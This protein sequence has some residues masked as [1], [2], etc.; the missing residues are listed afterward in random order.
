MLKPEL[1][2]WIVGYCS[3]LHFCRLE[4]RSLIRLRRE[5]LTVCIH[6][7]SPKAKRE[8]AT[9]EEGNRGDTGKGVLPQRIEF[10]VPTGAPLLHV[11]ILFAKWKK[12]PIPCSRDPSF[13][14]LG[15]PNKTI[16]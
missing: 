1:L 9:L 15:E 2:P 7:Q 4:Y 3:S 6:K 12:L 8:A 11:I 13:F 5:L 10:I 16:V 14:M